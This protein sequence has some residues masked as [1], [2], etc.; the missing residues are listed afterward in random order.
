[1]VCRV[2]KKSS[3]AKK[4][5]SDSLAM[6][7][8][9]ESPCN[10]ASLSE[11]GEIDVSVFNNLVHNSNSNSM[12][13]QIN[14]GMYGDSGSNVKL[15]ANMQTNWMNGQGS[16]PWAAAALFGAGFAAPNPAML[17]A[18]ALSRPD[19]AINAA[20]LSQFMAQGA[21]SSSK[22]VGCAEQEAQLFNQEPVWRGY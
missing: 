8:L 17:K 22:G 16:V 1:M 15:D 5:H 13:M 12:A 20:S 11:L 4:P 14:E 7:A 19:H 21:A 9:L 2:F 3:A 6:P 10:T 18:L